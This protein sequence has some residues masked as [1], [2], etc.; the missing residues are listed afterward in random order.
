MGHKEQEKGSKKHK[1]GSVEFKRGAAELVCRGGRRQW[2]V[3]GSLGVPANL[4][5][6]WVVEYSEKGGE[7][8]PGK[9]KL[10][11]SDEKVVGWSFSES[12]HA[13]LVVGALEMAA[14]HREVVPGLLGE[15][16]VLPDHIPFVS[17]VLDGTLLWRHKGEAVFSLCAKG[18]SLSWCVPV[19]TRT[20]I[21][22]R[23]CVQKNL[24]Y[25]PVRVSP[26]FKKMY[27]FYTHG[28]IQ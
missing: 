23:G 19:R 22:K 20:E 12:L 8:Y 3:A 7:A 4:V 21:A 11:L 17:A 16:G 27:F 5:S 24:W 18:V 25:S 10:A 1:Y 28:C 9:G 6:W 13:I 2:D 14:S 15:F 26:V